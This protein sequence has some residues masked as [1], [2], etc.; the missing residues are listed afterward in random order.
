MTGLARAER[1]ALCDLLAALGADEPTLCEG[2]LTRDLAAHLVLREGR[3]D[4]TPGIVVPAWAGWTKRVQD[5]LASGD[6]RRLVYRL[7]NGPPL[8]SPFR[9][10][11]VD[12]V[13]NG[14]ELFV[15][16]ED[17]RRAQPE[18]RP[19]AL[20]P[21]VEQLLWRRACR[22]AS[23]VFRSAHC[24]VE[25]VRETPG[26]RRL[27]RA[28]RPGQHTVTLRGAA[29]ELLMY[30]YGRRDHALLDV[31]GGVLPYPGCVSARTTTQHRPSPGSRSAWTDG[32][33]PSPVTMPSTKATLSPHTIC[34]SLSTSAWNGQLAARIAR[35][36]SPSQG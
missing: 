35:S 24:G 8:W 13:A 36:L 6:F 33:P 12:E 31:S 1:A 21:D 32:A 15:H 22:M 34:R 9:L 11:G 26:E 4:A 10:P 28:P 7:R 2:W 5:S 29:S 30:L 17:V 20:P 14:I 23:L 27:V 19:R 18:W 3:L 16:H 25:L